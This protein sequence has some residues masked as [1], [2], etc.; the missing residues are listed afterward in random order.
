MDPLELEG[1][2]PLGDSELY[3][4]SEHTFLDHGSSKS[5]ITSLAF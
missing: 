4:Y 5:T 1:T 2:D 3:N